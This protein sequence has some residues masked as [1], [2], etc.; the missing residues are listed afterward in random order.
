MLSDKIS[1]TSLFSQW[2]LLRIENHTPYGFFLKLD[3]GGIIIKY[4]LVNCIL[5]M[6]LDLI[7]DRGESVTFSEGDRFYEVTIDSRFDIDTLQW[8]VRTLTMRHE[9]SPQI[10]YECLT[11]NIIM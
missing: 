4:C 2:K 11:E 8:A 9:S 7:D 1:I 5:A 3:R 6:D 10:E